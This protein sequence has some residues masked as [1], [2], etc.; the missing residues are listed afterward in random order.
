MCDLSPLTPFIAEL[1]LQSA[2]P[3]PP[4]AGPSRDVPELCSPLTERAGAGDS[5]EEPRA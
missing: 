4:P 1:R 5:S 3:S 2:T